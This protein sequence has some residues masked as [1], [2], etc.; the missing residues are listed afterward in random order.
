MRAKRTGRHQGGLGRVEMDRF[1]TH[2]ADAGMGRDGG[3]HRGR[4]DFAIDGQAFPGG[5]AGGFGEGDQARAHAP[6]FG[7]EEPMG[8]S[9]GQALE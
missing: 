3:F 8:G 2:Q 4:K 1:L 9:E 6:E 5:H 7:F